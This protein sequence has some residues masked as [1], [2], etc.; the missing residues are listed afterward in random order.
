[1]PEWIKPIIEHGKPTQWNWTVWNPEK[2]VLGENIDIGTRTDIFAKYGV[3][4]EDDVQIGGHCLI[5]SEDTIS[6]KHGPVVLRRGCKIGANSVIFPNVTIG[7]GTLIKA[8]SIV[9][10]IIHV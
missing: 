9:K 1:M 5:Y 2:F 8:G 7:E 10:E 3:T 6:N 4:I